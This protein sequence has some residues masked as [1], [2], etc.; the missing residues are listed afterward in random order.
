MTEIR[1]PKIVGNLSFLKR[2]SRQE[3]VTICQP[4]FQR[5]LDPVE[6]AL[7]DAQVEKDEIN[8]IVMV[9]GTSRMP[10]LRP[11]LNEFF[12]REMLYSDGID[13]EQVVASGAT[14]LAGI[15]AP[16]STVKPDIVLHD[17]TPLTLGVQVTHEV[18]RGFLAKLF[19]SAEY[20]NK[21]MPVIKKNSSIPTE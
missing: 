9:G 8:D 3:F 20:V 13:P 2:L 12:G 17:I 18:E 4:L 21:M 6:A 16:H 5:I 19:T 1:Y 14:I 11:M 7:L 10:Q 15:L